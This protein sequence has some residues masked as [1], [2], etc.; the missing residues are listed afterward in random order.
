MRINE[1]EI[2]RGETPDEIKK[3]SDIIWRFYQEWRTENPKQRVYNH[4]VKDYIHVRQ[5]SI[6]E[7]ARHASKRYLSTLAVLQKI[8]ISSSI[9]TAR[10]PFGGLLKA[11]KT[12]TIQ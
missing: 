1:D 2:P 8:N 3:R 4:S 9:R 6:D 12:I 11:I 7:T 5:I 10:T